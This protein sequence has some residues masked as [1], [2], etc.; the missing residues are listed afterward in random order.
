MQFVPLD[1][2]YSDGTPCE[3]KMFFL[4]VLA[5]FTANEIVD[6][7]RSE[8]RAEERS[9][10]ARDPNDPPIISISYHP[11]GGAMQSSI[12]L[13]KAAI[14]NHAVWRITAAWPDSLYVSDAA[15]EAWEKTG[16]SGLELL[17]DQRSLMAAS[18]RED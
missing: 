5:A 9:H 3:K 18:G 13:K 15:I 10:Q 4:Y 1:I 12:V 2:V 6:L 7:E 8:V 17:S 11:L 16:V 14:G